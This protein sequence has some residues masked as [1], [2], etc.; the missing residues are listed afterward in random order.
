LDY[1]TDD[2]SVNLYWQT[3][4][5]DGSG[6]GWRNIEDGLWGLVYKNHT[7]QKPLIESAVYE[8]LHTTDQSGEHHRIDGEIVGGNDNYFNHTI[9]NSGWAYHSYIIDIHGNKST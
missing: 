2:F 4:F 6:M 3:I 7:K 1:Q 9:Y 8:F 5:E